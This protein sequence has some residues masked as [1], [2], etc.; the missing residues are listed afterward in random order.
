M[1]K[2]AIFKSN[3]VR[4]TL[5][6]LLGL[7]ALSNKNLMPDPVNAGTPPVLLGSYAP[8]YLGTQTA[9]D[10]QLRQIDTWAG[11]RMS[12]AGIFMDLEDS[13]PAYNIPVPLELLRRNGYTAFINFTSNRTAA[14]IANGSIDPA[15][16]RMAQAYA[17]WIS[18]GTGRMAF[19]APLPE[20]NGSWE[21]YKEDPA[22]FKL[23]YQRI[24]RIFTEAG[25]PRSAVRWVF[26]PNGWSATSTHNF[27]NYYPGNTRV[28]VVAFSAYN[29]GHCS[30]ASWKSWDGPS[31]VFAPYINRMRVMAP[32]KPIFIAQTATTSYTASGSQQAAKDQ[33]FRNSYSYLAQAPGVR[34]IIYFN[35]NK[36]CDWSLYDS[37]VKSLGYK[38]AVANP[39]FNYVSP[40]SLYQLRMTP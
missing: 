34:A 38:Q 13:N 3:K 19:L 8:N 36:E 2:L 7:T 4:L 17:S 40:S 22:N 15:I 23:A 26:A 25:V 24:Q 29:W 28:D 32:T 39:G 30:A 6:L 33:W 11:K 18:Q 35:L 9:I 27:E 14:Q 16:R 21:T 1:P 10:T 37:S 20:M 31:V 12:I 5:L